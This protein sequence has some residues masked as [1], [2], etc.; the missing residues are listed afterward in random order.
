MMTDAVGLML[1]GV[2]L[3]TMFSTCMDCFEY[4]RVGR[5][6]GRDVTRY[7]LRLDLLRLRFSRWGAASGVYEQTALPTQEQ[8]PTTDLLLQIEELFK[9]TEER[10]QASQSRSSARN[11]LAEEHAIEGAILPL[12]GS[13]RDIVTQRQKSSSYLKRARWALYGEA[14]VEKLVGDLTQLINSLYQVTPGLEKQEIVLCQKEVEEM[15]QKESHRVAVA[16]KEAATDVDAAL[17]EAFRKTTI[18]DQSAYFY[19]HVFA[20]GASKQLNGPQLTQDTQM[21][22]GGMYR[23]EDVVSYDQSKQHNGVLVVSVGSKGFLDE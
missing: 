12:C 14:E 10:M 16:V 20:K 11:P 9:F 18:G 3:A 23:Y 8:R 17:A 13:L 2:S 4:V 5:Q 7:Q 6:F 19:D 22:P 15:I 21:L 1:S